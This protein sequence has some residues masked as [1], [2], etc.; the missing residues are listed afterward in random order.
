MI[1]HLDVAIRPSGETTSFANDVAGI[2]ALVE[3]LTAL[4]PTRI[5]LEAT[6]GYEAPLVAAL[7]TGGLPAVWINPRQA[8]DFARAIGRLA[9]TDRLVAQVLDHFA[10]AVRPPVRALPDAQVQELAVLLTWRTQLLEM[11]T[12]ERNRVCLASPTV[13]ERLPAH[14]L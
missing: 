5:V 11:L 12:A 1:E 13:R 2:A 14:I 4:C 3:K 10:N 7:A 6:G 9:K 8:R